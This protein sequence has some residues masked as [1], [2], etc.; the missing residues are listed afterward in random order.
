MKRMMLLLLVL[1]TTG[2][3]ELPIRP[4]P[5]AKFMKEPKTA[6][7]K[8]PTNQTPAPA[9]DAPPVTP[10]QVNDGNA[11]QMLNALREEMDHAANEH[12]TEPKP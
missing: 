9:M 1:T 4:N 8:A 12:A 3:I 2:C 7:A 6:A 10:E 11:P 5:D